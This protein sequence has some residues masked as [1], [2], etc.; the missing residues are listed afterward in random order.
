M[1]VWVKENGNPHMSHTFLTFKVKGR[2]RFAEA[3]GAK[4]GHTGWHSPRSTAGFEP[5]HWPGT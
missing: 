5:R 1:T 4:S 2:T 3:G